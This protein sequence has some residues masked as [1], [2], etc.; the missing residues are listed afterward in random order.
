MFTAACG[1]V[2]YDLRLSD[3]RAVFETLWTWSLRRAVPD[4][5]LIGIWTHG[6]W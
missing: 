4:S 3:I 2:I 6:F 1:F 5:D